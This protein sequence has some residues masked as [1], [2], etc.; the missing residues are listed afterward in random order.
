MVEGETT[1]ADPKRVETKYMDAMD[2][3]SKTNRRGYGV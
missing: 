3:Q 2:W 1:M